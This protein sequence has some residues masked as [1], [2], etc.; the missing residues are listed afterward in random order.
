MVFTWVI[1]FKILII[2]LI[3]HIPYT[4]LNALFYFIIKKE[5]RGRGKKG[6]NQ[7]G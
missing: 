2:L 6:K 4:H 3:I 7:P 1:I 5:E